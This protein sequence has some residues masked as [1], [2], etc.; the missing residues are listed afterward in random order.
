MNTKP[1]VSFDEDKFDLAK[2]KEAAEAIVK[3]KARTN[4]IRKQVRRG[5][6]ILAIATIAIFFALFYIAAQIGL[7][8]VF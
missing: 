4:R 3:E 7:M 5:K 6:I 2:H 1:T 8:Q